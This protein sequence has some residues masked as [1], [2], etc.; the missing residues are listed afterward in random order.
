V[1]VD[2]SD[3]AV[4]GVLL[5]TDK[6]GKEHPVAYFSNTLKRQQRDWSPYSKEAFAIVMA[7]RDTG[8]YTRLLTSLLR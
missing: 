6:R 2:A 8:K 7:R 4:G 5:Q 3:V 1:E